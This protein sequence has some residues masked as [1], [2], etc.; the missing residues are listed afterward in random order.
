MKFIYFVFS[1][2]D[3]AEQLR[4]RFQNQLNKVDLNR[5][6]SGD[7]VSQWHTD[8]VRLRA[9]KVGAQVCSYAQLIDR[10]YSKCCT[11]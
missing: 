11:F 7:N 1:H 4:S 6:S 9:G 3:L 8:M 2:N 10:L 5:N